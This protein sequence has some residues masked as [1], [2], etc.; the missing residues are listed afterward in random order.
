MRTFSHLFGEHCTAE[1]RRLW[2]IP[3]VFGDGP[4]QPQSSERQETTEITIT[5]EGVRVQSDTAEE[6]EDSVQH[7]AIGRMEQGARETEREEDLWTK[8][9]REMSALLES[10]K[11]LP[12]EEQGARIRAFNEQILHPLGLHLHLIDGPMRLSNHTPSDPRMAI[13]KAKIAELT[14]EISR[15]TI[16]IHQARIHGIAPMAREYRGYKRGLTRRGNIAP[17]ISRF[18]MQFPVAGASALAP[19]LKKMY[20]HL[21]KKQMEL[22]QLK[23]RGWQSMPMPAPS[24]SPADGAPIREESA[25]RFDRRV[26]VDRLEFS[27]GLSTLDPATQEQIKS[28]SPEFQRAIGGVV[29]GLDE[30]G[31]SNL[32]SLT[33]KL[34]G[35]DRNLRVKASLVNPDGTLR[36][37]QEIR[38]EITSHPTEAK[39]LEAIATFIE[40]LSPGEK[41]VMELLIKQAR[42]LNAGAEQNATSAEKIARYKDAWTKAKE[43]GDEPGMEMAE[44]LLMMNGM[45]IDET[46]KLTPLEDGFGGRGMGTIVG[47]ILFIDGFLKKIGEKMDKKAKKEN[48]EK[49]DAPTQDMTQEQKTEKIKESEKRIGGLKKEQKDLK[50]QIKKGEEELEKEHVETKNVLQMRLDDLK[51]DLKKVEENIQKEEKKLEDLQKVVPRATAEGKDSEKTDPILTNFATSKVKFVQEFQK[52]FEEKIQ[53]MNLSDEEVK[54]MMESLRAYNEVMMK[55]LSIEKNTDG[56]YRIVFDIPSMATE[57]QSMPALQAF[58]INDE[59]R[60]NMHTMM[61][62]AFPSLEMKIEGGKILSAW[63]SADVIKAIEL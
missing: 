56:K 41:K 54:P 62:K 21:A 60:T 10:I 52:D 4:E 43:S 38:A 22:A 28:L 45:E 25:P 58:T 50:D 39:A 5:P 31:K 1:A 46:G 30:Q 23:Q 26:P 49:D 29:D 63:V 20:E 55:H 36:S 33:E 47:F 9:N 12:T 19:D 13:Y 61:M 7:E 32:G 2:N 16:A 14:T 53:M 37:P 3:D 11:G 15:T 51:K 59:D 24:P 34:T 42:Q 17:E 48:K 6:M 27:R 8:V 18:M 35:I 57:V 44:G 40:S